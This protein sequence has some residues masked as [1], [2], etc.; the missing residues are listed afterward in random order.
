MRVSRRPHGLMVTAFD[1]AAA[2]RVHRPAPPR[3]PPTIGIGLRAPAY[4][5]ERGSTTHDDHLHGSLL[6][7]TR[8]VVIDLVW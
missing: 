2:L 1:G 7:P 5:T 4:E 3:S 6:T 8:T